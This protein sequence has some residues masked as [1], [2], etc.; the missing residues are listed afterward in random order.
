MRK[1]KPWAVDPRRV[2]LFK[3]KLR[4]ILIGLDRPRFERSSGG[5]ALILDLRAYK[6]RR[7]AIKYASSRLRM[8]RIDFDAKEFWAGSCL[9]NGSP[10]YLSIPLDQEALPERARVKELP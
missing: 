3:K 8:F 4:S 10:D 2:Q 6:N 7:E 1:S 9:A 5:T